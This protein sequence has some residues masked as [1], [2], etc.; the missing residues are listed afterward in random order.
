MKALPRFGA[1]AGQRLAL[2]IWQFVYKRA[3]CSCWCKL[4]GLSKGNEHGWSGIE[5]GEGPLRRCYSI[6]VLRYRRGVYGRDGVT[7]RGRHYT[8]LPDNRRIGRSAR[9]TAGS[10]QGTDYQDG[11]GRFSATMTLNAED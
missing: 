9:H 5:S 4:R 7:I 3:M 1:S 8:C 6:H 11:R 10:A 2:G